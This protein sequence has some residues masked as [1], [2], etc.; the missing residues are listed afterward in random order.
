M[1]RPQGDG[2][3]SRMNPLLYALIGL[4]TGA[5]VVM[6]V[7][8]IARRKRD[9]DSQLVKRFELLETKLVN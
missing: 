2:Y 6:I 8:A 7:F 4:L 5:G 9:D 1:R 3:I